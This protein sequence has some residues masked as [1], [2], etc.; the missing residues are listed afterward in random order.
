[1]RNELHRDFGLCQSLSVLLIL[2]KRPGVTTLPHCEKAKSWLVFG[3]KQKE[4]EYD[5]LNIADV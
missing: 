5:D 2:L 3:D 4:E 1:M